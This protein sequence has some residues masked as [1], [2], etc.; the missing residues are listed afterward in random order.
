MRKLNLNVYSLVECFLPYSVRVIALHWNDFKVF[1]YQTLNTESPS[2]SQ[3][4][5][6]IYHSVKKNKTSSTG[7]LAQH[8][9]I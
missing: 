7:K 9:S 4:I 1:S 2:P 5:C 6:H 3:L 8:K